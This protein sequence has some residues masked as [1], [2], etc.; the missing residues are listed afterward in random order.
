M[1]GVSREVARRLL[2][3]HYAASS[4]HGTV[5]VLDTGS[6]APLIG[7][8]AC[9]AHVEWGVPAADIPLGRLVISALPTGL[10]VLHRVVASRRTP[11]GNLEL[12][13]LPDADDGD[14]PGLPARYVPLPAGYASPWVPE[15]S[16][17]GMVTGV[18]SVTGSCLYDVG[19]VYSRATD[20]L[21]LWFARRLGAGSGWDDGR[22]RRLLRRARHLSLRL[23]RL[24]SSAAWQ[25]RAHRLAGKGSLPPPGTFFA[26][27]SEP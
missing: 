15:R 25:V 7:G 10:V 14:V 5:R 17:L 19:S 23:A 3:R 16:V 24:L 26:R 1:T 13:H 21:A 9:V 2:L 6:M 27:R 11:A 22:P 8:G 18:T 12:L 4:P 20:L